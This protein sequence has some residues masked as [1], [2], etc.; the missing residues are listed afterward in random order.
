MISILIDGQSGSGKTTLARE[1]AA[2][3]G[4][5]VVHL[6]DFYPGWAGLAQASRMVATDVLHPTSPGFWRW[7]WEQHRRAEWVAIRPGASLVIEGC[8]AVSAASISMARTLGTVITV[9][10]TAPEPIRKQRA[11]ARD[12]GYAPWWEMWA[13]QEREHFAGPGNVPVE[14]VLGLAGTR[15]G[16]HDC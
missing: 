10:I 13:Q 16:P 2:D 12:P 9:R 3:T 1:L 8:G 4:F 11:L 15:D 7:D 14:H 5:Q 6:E